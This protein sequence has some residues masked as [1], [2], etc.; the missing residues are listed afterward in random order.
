M[1]T[2]EALN[3][4]EEIN[5]LIQASN[6]ALLS[7]RYLYLYGIW[8]SVA[9]FCFWIIYRIFG[10][11]ERVGIMSAVV[12]AILGLL[13]R[14]FMTKTP[15]TE[16]TKLNPVI[17]KAFSL[18][19]QMR[20]AFIGAIVI[21]AITNQVTMMFPFFLLFIGLLFSIYGMFSSKIVTNFAWSYIVCG[22]LAT[23]AAKI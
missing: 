20:V 14:K 2:N 13:V 6:E 22:L 9:P 4:I 5:A 21:L 7:P 19:L 23:Y 16:E 1:E 12:F 17:K 18:R 3:K 11:G 10:G 15:L 8:L